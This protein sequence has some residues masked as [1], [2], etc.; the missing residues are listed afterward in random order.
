MGERFEQYPYGPFRGEVN[1]PWMEPLVELATYA[2]VTRNIKLS[3]GVIIAP[4]RPAALLAKQIA[5]L[6]TL[7]RGRVSIG[8]G[9]GWQQDEYIACGV[10]W[11]QR[12]NL[13]EEQIRVCRALWGQAPV[14]F[15]GETV[16]FDGLRTMPFPPQGARIPI[17]LGVAPKR[18]NIERIAELADGWL[19]MERNP[20]ELKAPIR[21][22][23]EAF[24][25]RGRDPATLEVRSA[26]EIVLGDNGRPDLEASLKS[27]Q[28]HA[29]VGVTNLRLE[30][31][32][33]CRRIE[34][35]EPFLERVVQLKDIRLPQAS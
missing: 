17:H 12:F 16:N 30:P 10:D 15:H 24:V 33:F 2:A 14:S 3:S 35:Y 21:K 26:H 11:D 27:S 25:A 31:R 23:R 9:V 18:R 8:L 22:L 34:E 13:L 28:D 4:L 20:E 5:T 29:A 1:S 6:D 7:S 32:V 19:P